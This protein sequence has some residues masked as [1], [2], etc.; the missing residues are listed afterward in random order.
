ME[1][2]LQ[3]PTRRRIYDAVS[4]HPGASAREVQRIVGLAWGETAYH[5][6]QLTRAGALRRERGGRRD[7]YFRLDMNW[8][9]RR[10]LQ[11]LRSET[12]RS[13]LVLLVDS[14][15]LTLGNLRD[16]TGLSLSTASLH[17]RHLRALGVVEAFSAGSL[18]QYRAVGPERLVELLRLYQESFQDRLVDRFLATWSSL[19]R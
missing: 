7:Y 9:D 8:E 17:V 16:R 14:P 10:L 2:A 13:I 4:A 5:L 1:E 18:R 3:Q 11:A 12:E 15:G 19:F 6:D